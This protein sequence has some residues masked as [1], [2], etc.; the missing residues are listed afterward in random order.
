LKSDFNCIE[1]QDCMTAEIG[2]GVAR[3]SNISEKI[4]LAPKR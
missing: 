3:D 1:C 4:S 2:R